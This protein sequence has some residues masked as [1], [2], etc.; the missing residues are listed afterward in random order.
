M[1]QYAT[2]MQTGSHWFPYPFASPRLGCTSRTYQDR[3]SQA[4]AKTY[5][6][7][8]QFCKRQFPPATGRRWSK[9][10][11]TRSL[12]KTKL[13]LV[14]GEIMTLASWSHQWS[15]TATHRHHRHL[16]HHSGNTRNTLINVYGLGLNRL[17][18]KR[19][20]ITFLL[21]GKGY[22]IKREQTLHL[23]HCRNYMAS[24]T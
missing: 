9:W 18:I 11:N 6:R 8:R 13:N 24:A 3:R 4:Y 12:N 22:E 1:T 7:L 23:Y 10:R 17:T 5:K 2:D 16:I 20:T 19:R 21:K 14:R 15:K